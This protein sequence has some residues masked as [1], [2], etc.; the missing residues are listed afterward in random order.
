MNTDEF[1]RPE[2]V[3]RS[4]VELEKVCWCAGCRVDVTAQRKAMITAQKKRQ[5]TFEERVIQENLGQDEDGCAW[6]ASFSYRL[7]H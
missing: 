1:K 3:L 5:M 2:K 7:L 4:E 6:S